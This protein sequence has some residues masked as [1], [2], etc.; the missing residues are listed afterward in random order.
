MSRPELY[1]RIDQRTDGMME[2]GLLDEVRHL[3]GMGY[4]P[5]LASMRST[6]YRELVQHLSGEVDLPEAI[7]RIK[8]ATHRLARRQYA[9]FRLD[10]PRIHWIDAATD[11][12]AQAAPLVRRFLAGELPCATMTTHRATERA[13][14]RGGDFP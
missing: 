11:P 8:Y 13:A 4:G 5:G 9:W 1:Q 3:S 6:G 2:S 7:Q 12:Y 14:K 10:D